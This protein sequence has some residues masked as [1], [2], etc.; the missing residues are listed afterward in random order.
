[1]RAE[2]PGADGGLAQATS[3]FLELRPRLFGIAYR[4]LGSVAE[5]EDILQEVW[6]RW[7]KTDRTVVVDPPASRLGRRASTHCCG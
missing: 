5:A 6:L 2:Q 3:A 1:M 4:M 7:Q